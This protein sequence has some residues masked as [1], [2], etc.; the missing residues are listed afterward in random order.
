MIMR[1]SLVITLMWVFIGSSNRPD[2]PRCQ[3]EIY[4]LRDTTAR[5][6]KFSEISLEDLVLA[7]SCWISSNDIAKY[8]WKNHEILLKDG[9][10]SLMSQFRDPMRGPD[11][12][13]VVVANGERIYKG[14]FWYSASSYIGPTVKISRI[15]G[16]RKGVRLE[17]PPLQ[18]TPDPRNDERIRKCLKEAGVLVD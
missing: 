7:D 10:S 3:F 2:T 8:I 17:A 15:N 5:A 9:V 6:Y 4:F 11:I 12:L 14:S 13:F 16:E 18:N 1:F